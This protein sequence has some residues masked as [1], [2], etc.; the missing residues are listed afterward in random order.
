MHGPILTLAALAVSWCTRN[1]YR[2]ARCL[3]S[4]AIICCHLIASSKIMSS[5]TPRQFGRQRGV[6]PWLY[7][8]IACVIFAI[9][10]QTLLVL[11]QNLSGHDSVGRSTSDAPLLNDEHQHQH[12]IDSHELSELRQSHLPHGTFYFGPHSHSVRSPKNK[13]SW[14][15]TQQQL[16]DDEEIDIEREKERCASYNFDFPKEDAPIKRRRLFL[17][18]LIADESMEV[19]QAIGTEAYD[20]FH[21][22]SF[23]ES[24]STPSL[25]PRKWRFL[26]SERPSR[27]FLHHIYQLYGPKTKVRGE[28][29][30]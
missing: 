13:Q 22:V 14:T 30:Y 1:L 9:V 6:S 29:L 8:L 2:K 17:G 28:I 19:L 16:L 12:Q 15:P 4:I 27:K 23:I 20:I 11:N 25:T 24:N 10:G 21:T 3:S 5:T 18:S 7:P 26:E